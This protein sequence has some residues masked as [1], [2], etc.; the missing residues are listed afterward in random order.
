MVGW[1][2]LVFDAGKGRFVIDQAAVDI[3]IAKLKR[4]LGNSKSVF[5]YVNALNNVQTST[6]NREITNTSTDQYST[7]SSS[8]NF[9][10]TTEPNLESLSTALSQ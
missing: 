1:A 5:G 6:V 2:F 10:G 4:Q 7:W 3:R 8:F 9:G